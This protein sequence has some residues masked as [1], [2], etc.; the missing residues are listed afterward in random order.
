MVVAALAWALVAPTRAYAADAQIDSFTINY[1]MQPSGVLKVKET[2]V[3]RFRQ[4][5]RAARIPT[6]SSDS[7][8]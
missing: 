4:Q 3:W 6:R 2:I 8:A 7:R 5:L 1:E